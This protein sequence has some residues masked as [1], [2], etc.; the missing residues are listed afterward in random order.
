[1]DLFIVDNQGKKRKALQKKCAFC[2][3]EYVVPTRFSNRSLY[4]STACNANAKRKRISIVCATCAKE[5]DKTPSKMKGSKHEIYFCSRACKDKAQRI[6][7]DVPL[8]VPPHYGTGHGAHDYRDRCGEKLE[9]GCVGCGELR[10][11]L[12][13]VHHIDANRS[14]NKDENLEVVCGKC[15]MIRHLK[16]KDGQWVYDSKVLTPRDI[17]QEMDK[18]FMGE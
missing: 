6:D 9:N 5:F 2:K 18:H 7:S 15:H 10:L 1:M 3:K 17:V 4:C 14:N 13:M 11:Y 12:L 8:V 16:E